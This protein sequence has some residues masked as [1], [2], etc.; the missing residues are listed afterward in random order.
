MSKASR[1]RARLDNPLYHRRQ[2][3]WP[4]RLEGRIYCDR[5]GRPI[6]RIYTRDSGARWAHFGD[7]FPAPAFGC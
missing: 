4:L 6:H 3:I 2:D 7:P 5:C 1:A